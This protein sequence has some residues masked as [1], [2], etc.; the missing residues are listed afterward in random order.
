MSTPTERK[1]ACEA[2][3]GDIG[4]GCDPGQ[5]EG[6]PGRLVGRSWARVGGSCVACGAGA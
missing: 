1:P 5:R 4:E 6:G 3:L 2:E